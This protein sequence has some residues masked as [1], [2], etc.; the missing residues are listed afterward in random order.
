MKQFPRLPLYRTLCLLA[1][2]A[3]WTVSFAQ[4]RITGKVSDGS[5]GEPLVGAS[6]SVAALGK[7][8]YSDEKGAYDLNLPAAK[9]PFEVQV[10]YNGYS[11]AVFTINP[12]DPN[13]TNRDITLS[14][15]GFTTEDVVIT[16][17]KGFQ[18]AQADVT[19]SIE[20][21][22]PRF[23]DLQALPSVDKALS[24]I[25]GVDNQ[26]GQINIRGSS[27]YAYGVG[28]RVMLTLDG[29]P[30]LTADAGTASLDMIPVDNI[31]QI[32]VMKGASSVLY[33]SSALGGVI[34]VITSDPGDKPRTAIRIRGG[35]F[36]LP[37]NPAIDWDGE[38]SPW[39]GS[40]HLFHSRR[41]GEKV[42]FTF[43]SNTI[44]ESGYRQGTDTE[45]YRNMFMLR[46]RPVNGLTLGLN[47]SLSVD[48]SGQILYWR[49]YYPD[50]TEVNGQEV[51]SGGA[52]TPTL[53]G[54]GYRRQLTY[55]LALDPT[56]KYLSKSGHLFWYRGRYLAGGNRNNTNQESNSFIF[57]NDFLY[58]K[59]LFNKVNFVVGATYTRSGIQGDSLYG[60][61][62]VING[63]TLVSDG[64]HTGDS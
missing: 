51:V 59:T 36:G 21:M 13:P 47:A 62:Y 2:L 41:I 8:V 28:S 61:T 34:N 54:G 6:V 18:Q 58:Q 25:P 5:T 15:E 38:K 9:P 63:D 29:L 37:S 57:Y 50:T 45:Q 60:G 1:S 53:D 24:Q 46:Y 49:G 44:K 23:L 55:E 35:V 32:E 16:A 26:D 33:G 64:S 40:V 42:D 17:T 20:V 11:T 43:Q 7:G 39:S 31:N 19:V 12:G 14:P 3:G 22:K 10:K 56:I 52:L 30:L 48:S 4:W 27:G